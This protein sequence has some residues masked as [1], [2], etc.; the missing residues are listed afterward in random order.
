M[1]DRVH[2]Q[3]LS[4]VLGHGHRASAVKQTDIH[5]HVH[6]LDQAEVHQLGLGWHVPAPIVVV[7]LE[8]LRLR[9]LAVR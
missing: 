5:G 4:D 2:S 7:H 8:S 3:L 1:A 9:R 6:L